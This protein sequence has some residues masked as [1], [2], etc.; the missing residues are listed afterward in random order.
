MR[1]RGLAGVLL[2]AVLLS[3]RLALAGAGLDVEAWLKKP[4]VRMLAV[5]F[6]ATWCKPC[7]AAVPRWAKLHERYEAQGLRLVV[8]ATRDPKGGC[9]NPGWNP[10]WSLNGEASSPCD[11]TFACGSLRGP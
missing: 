4:G 3:P 8:V 2:A 7:M 10:Y 9:V 6:Y 1:L 5:E 11:P